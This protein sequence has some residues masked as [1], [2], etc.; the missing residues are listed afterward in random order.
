MEANDL[1]NELGYRPNE[2]EESR[3]PAIYEHA[4]NAYAAMEERASVTVLNDSGEEGLVYEGFLTKL[5]T[6]ELNLS[7]PYYTK[8]LN[9]L[10]RMDCVRQLRRGGST[11]QSRWV[12]LRKPTEEL[13]RK[14]RPVKTAG[15][16]RV[17]TL[18]QQV[19][20]LNKRLHDAGL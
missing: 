5:I 18:E 10:K 14:M 16:S 20:D 12:L 6:T 7:L 4:Q 3:L 11:T 17:E 8:I 1:T 15:S 19:R 2:V 13:F 9:E